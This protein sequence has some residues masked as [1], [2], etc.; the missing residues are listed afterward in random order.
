M[1]VKGMAAG[2]DDDAGRRRNAMGF[3]G[4]LKFEN[5]NGVGLRKAPTWPSGYGS[6]TAAGC[7]AVRLIAICDDCRNW[8]TRNRSFTADQVERIASAQN[9]HY[10][11]D[12]SI[13]RAFRATCN[14]YVDKV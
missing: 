12:A 4:R 14:R 6:A 8:L 10:G 2:D 5:A 7:T 11:V 1:L 3:K 9:E 13:G